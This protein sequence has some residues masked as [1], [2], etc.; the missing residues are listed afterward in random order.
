MI[1]SINA[2]PV[3]DAETLMATI[4]GYKPNDTITIKFKRDGKEE[5]VKATLGKR[6]ASS[7]RGD[8][9]NRL[10]SELSER[11]GG[12]PSILQHDTVLKPGSCGGP[13]VDLDGNVI[14]INIA[15]A[16][17]TESYALPSE[18]VLA[19]LDELKS[20]KLAPA[21]TVKDPDTTKV[22]ETPAVKKARQAVADAQ[23]KVRSAE[24]KAATAKKLLDEARVA[25]EK[26]GK[27]DPDVIEVHNRSKDIAAKA[28]QVLA[29]ARKLQETANA[30]LKKAEAEAKEKK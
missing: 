15:R 1:L 11:R 10:G 27:T 26:F 3:P 8:F 24:Q 25:A 2:K 20:G 5:E 17:R 22:P 9:Q 28:D 23:D 16:G 6:P 21:G 14:G 12:F 18:T 30:E 13:L 29:E 7:T 4:G 19:L